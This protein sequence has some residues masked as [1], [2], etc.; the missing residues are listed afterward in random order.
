MHFHVLLLAIASLAYAETRT[1]KYEVYTATKRKLVAPN[2]LDVNRTNDE[3]GLA[4][5]KKFD[6][7]KY[8]YVSA[9]SLATKNGR[10]TDRVQAHSKN[11]V[12][13]S[14]DNGIGSLAARIALTERNRNLD[15]T[16]DF[17][18][19]WFSGQRK[20]VKSAGKSEMQQ[21]KLGVQDAFDLVV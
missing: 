15:Y 1:F 6:G 12:L 3:T 16:L 19:V 4:V 20:S 2:L 11:N 17:N 9:V 18:E 21:A 8:Q 10:D 5:P 14:W 7:L 13:I